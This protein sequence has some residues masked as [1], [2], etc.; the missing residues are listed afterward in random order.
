MDGGQRDLDIVLYGASGFVGRLTASYLARM[1]EGLRVALAGRSADKLHS[2]RQSL[3]GPAQDWPVLVADLSDYTQLTKLACR[4]RVMASAVGPYLKSGLPIVA[5]CA[6][7]GTDYVDVTGEGPFVRT[8]IDICDSQA[9][10]TGA[11]IV[12]SCGFD[13]VPS[14]LTVYAL[15][16][17]AVADGAGELAETTLVLRRFSG[18]IS[19]GS[20]ATMVELLRISADPDMRRLL[21]DPYSLSPDR[22][23]EPDLGPQPDV[24]L[25]RGSEVA[26]ELAG[27]WTGGYVM[28][29]YNT[30]CV[31]RTNAL[32]GWAYGRGLRYTETMSL[33]SSRFAPMLAT[34]TSA[35]IAG[36]NRFAGTYLSMLP[37]SVIDGMTT[38]S[39]IGYADDNRGHYTVE[40]YTRTTSGARYVATM[41]QQADP[42]YTAT[43]LM[44]GESARTLVVKPEDLP[45]RR[46]VLTPVTAMGDALVSRLS[47][48]G[49]TL[50]V[51]RL[52]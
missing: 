34:M 12:H 48:A 32:L 30:R 7:T 5:V 8:S 43:A 26:P 17:R 41:S 44:L 11:R 22:R 46:G 6:A 39:G 1:G 51:A 20:A 35:T 33:G 40:T 3:G 28:A 37:T 15:H 21:D 14:D 29:A 10:A 18:G 27:L 25:R 9:V 52:N 38:S 42:G 13:S 19:G 47:A 23:G 31:R 45:D 24:Q 16:R 50:S 4:T 49:V 36:A 2:L